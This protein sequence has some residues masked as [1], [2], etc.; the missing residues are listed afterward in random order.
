MFAA[1]LLA[2]NRLGTAGVLQA[3]RLLHAERT[4][5]PSADQH[6]RPT[7]SRRRKARGGEGAYTLS[8]LD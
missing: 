1:A 3:E 7:G 6:V 8:T 2:S 4:P 5:T